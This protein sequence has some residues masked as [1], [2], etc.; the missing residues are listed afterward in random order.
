M[1]FDFSH[2]HFFERFVSKKYVFC[3][4]RLVSKKYVLYRNFG[5]ADANRLC[6]HIKASKINAGDYV[7]KNQY[8]SVPVKCQ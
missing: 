5:V 8:V 6:G 2:F 7:I 3:R 1:F 4:K